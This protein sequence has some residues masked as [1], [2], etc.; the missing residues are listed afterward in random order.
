MSIVAVLRIPNA[1]GDRVKLR[2]AYQVK[3]MYGSAVVN[4]PSRVMMQMGAPT[5][6]LS[7]RTATCST[8]NTQHGHHVDYCSAAYLPAEWFGTS[9][10]SSSVTVTLYDSTNSGLVQSS[11][12]VGA[13]TLNARPIWWDAALQ[14]STVG[15]GLSAPAGVPSTGG[16][17]ISLPT[18]PVHAGES[19]RVYM[20][21]HTAG[22][23]LSAWRVR[24]YFV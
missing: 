7:A 21:A 8:G 13:L 12:S 22:L 4:R 3:D 10:R 16:I 11:V 6:S 23:S 17:F 19:L 1:W 20:Y 14:S 18:S 2:V 9:Q 5:A 24:L 15:N